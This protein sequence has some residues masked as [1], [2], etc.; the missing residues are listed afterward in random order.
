MKAIDLVKGMRVET[1]KGTKVVQTSTYVN[2]NSQR[3]SFADGEICLC[4]PNQDFT[5]EADSYEGNV[6]VCCHNVVFWYNLAPLSYQ[7]T[8]F[9]A[10]LEKALTEEASDRA[11]AM[12]TDGYSSGE[13]NCLWQGAIEI[14]GSWKI[15]T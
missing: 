8:E 13:L 9:T 4:P 12:I 14:R 6:E 11:K 15:A 10:E 7:A 1:A 3:V 2:R 5:V